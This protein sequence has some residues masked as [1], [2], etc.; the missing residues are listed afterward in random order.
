LKK[1]SQTKTLAQQFG[2]MKSSF[3]EFSTSIA[4]N[5]LHVSGS[6]RPTARSNIYIFSLTYKLNKHPKI[7]IISP[8]IIR[9]DKDEEIPHMYSQEFLCLYQPKYRQFRDCEYLS[10]TLIP[11]ISLWLYYYEKWHITGDWHG[12]G[13]HTNS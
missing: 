12:G 4:N 5:T 3:K 8:A 7:K 2:R 1:Q 6:V 10:E 9:N 13:E 11:W